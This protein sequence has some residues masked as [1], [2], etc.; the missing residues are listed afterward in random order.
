MAAKTQISHAFIRVN[1]VKMDPLQPVRSLAVADWL[2]MFA[3]E[4]I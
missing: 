2:P 4:R 1:D 3:A